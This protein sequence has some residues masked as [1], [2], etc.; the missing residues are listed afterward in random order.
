MEDQAFSPFLY[1]KHI[2]LFY[3]LYG[4]KGPKMTFVSGYLLKWKSASIFYI[5]ENISIFMRFCIYMERINKNCIYFPENIEWLT[6]DLTF[7]PSY[8]LAPPPPLSRR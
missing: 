8:D 2:V 5:C 6:E 7:S 1:L 4:L 3:I